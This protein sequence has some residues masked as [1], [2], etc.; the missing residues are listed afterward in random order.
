MVAVFANRRLVASLMSRVVQLENLAWTS[1]LAEDAL[2]Q[3]AGADPLV[4]LIGVGLLDQPQVRGDL[5]AVL[6]AGREHPLELVEGLGSDRVEVEGKPEILAVSR[7]DDDLGVSRGAAYH[8]AAQLVVGVAVGRQRK[9]PFPGDLL[10]DPRELVGVL[11]RGD[12]GVAKGEE[13]RERADEAERG[14]KRD[15]GEAPARGGRA[16]ALRGRGR[17]GVGFE[18]RGVEQGPDDQQH[19]QRRRDRERL[20]LHV[21]P[22]LDQGAEVDHERPQD[23]Q[24]DGERSPADPPQRRDREGGDAE[25]PEQDPERRAGGPG[26]EV[27]VGPGSE[28]LQRGDGVAE[29]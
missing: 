11:V 7:G 3:A 18:G 16:L 24:G 10:S 4:E 23:P 17:G 22:A 20:R 8:R 28:R 21:E 5:G 14:R 19:H 12:D 27:A 15:P 29:L 25:G 9:R 26:E 1:F 2:V 6:G 13:R